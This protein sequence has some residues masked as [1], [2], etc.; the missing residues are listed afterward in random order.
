MRRLARYYPLWLEL[1]LVYLVFLSFWYPVTHYAEMPQRIPT[2]FGASGQP[3]AW[4]DKS[5]ASVLTLPLILAGVYAGLTGLAGYMAGVKDP[6]KLINVSPKQLEKIT[7]E[8]AE[9]IRRTVIRFLMGEK[10]L[11]V[12]MLSYLSYAETMT[13][14]G[15]WAGLGWVAWLFVAALVGSSA[16]LT[17]YVLG[18]VYSA[19]SPTRRRT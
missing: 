14:L 15:R 12:A 1:I 7:P 16:F 10:S 8:R 19:G 5:W 6:K 11:L 17:A 2:H 4:A 13:A 9:A 3:D 18:Q